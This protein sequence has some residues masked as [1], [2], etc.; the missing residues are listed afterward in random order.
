MVAV[1]WS[2]LGILALVSMSFVGFAWV[3]LSR[4]SSDMNARFDQTNAAIAK[5]G[6]DLN[7][8]IDKTNS[9]MNARIDKASSDMNA[10]ID[11]QGAETRSEIGG[12]RTEIAELRVLVI[13]TNSRIDSLGERIANLE[14]H[15]V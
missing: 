2:A 14:S 7:T 3:Q 11:Q 1:T 4:L 6:S 10:R 8:R 13:S 12:V 15:R 9:D 5:L